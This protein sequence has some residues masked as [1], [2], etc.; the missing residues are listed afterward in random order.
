MGLLIAAAVI[1]SVPLTSH[2]EIGD[3]VK[4][5]D[6]T[7][8]ITE[9]TKTATDET[10]QLVQVKTDDVRVKREDIQ[11]KMAEKK[12]QIQDKLSNTRKDVC[13]KKEVKINQM[14]DTRATKAEQ[15]LAK[16]DAINERLTSFVAQ[17]HLTVENSAPMSLILPDAQAEATAMVAESKGLDFSCVDTSSSSPGKDITDMFADEKQALRD[18]QTALREYAGAVK[19]AAKKAEVTARKKEE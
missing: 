7:K 4:T 17:K 3:I 18:Y 19:D 8:V 9:Q 13:L 11:A 15:M 14:I 5:D 1:A 6:V 12:A 10:Q 16:F 2:A